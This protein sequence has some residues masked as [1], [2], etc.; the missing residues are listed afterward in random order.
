MEGLIAL[1]AIISC[2]LGII[3]FFKVWMACN[4]IKRIRVK[5]LNS[6]NSQ[7]SYAKAGETRSKT[8]LSVWSSDLQRLNEMLSKRD[9]LQS[10]ID[11]LN[12]FLKKRSEDLKKYTCKGNEQHAMALWKELIDRITPIYE[13]LGST[14]PREYINFAL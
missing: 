14:P 10:K 8:K 3:L 7:S 1:I 11:C 13:N 4:D 9:S 2:V 6:D 12:T 5:L